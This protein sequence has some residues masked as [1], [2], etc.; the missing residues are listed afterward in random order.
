MRSTINSRFDA[1]ILGTTAVGRYPAVLPRISGRAWIYATMHLG[2][3]PSD[4]YQLGFTMADTWGTG[5][6]HVIPED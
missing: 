3:D 2:A 1:S 5:I 4:P 6:D